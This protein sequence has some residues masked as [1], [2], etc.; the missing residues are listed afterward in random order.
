MG[1]A[2]D[3]RG[4]PVDGGVKALLEGHSDAG[5]D[6]KSEEEEEEEETGGE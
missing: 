4:P 5:A 3:T 1:S 6:Y 2:R